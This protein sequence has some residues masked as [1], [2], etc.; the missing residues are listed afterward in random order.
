MIN[1]LAKKIIIYGIFVIVFIIIVSL[2]GFLSSI[3]PP[4]IRID[5]K[6]ADFGLDH[7]EVTFESADGLKLSGWFIP[8]NKSEDAIIVMHGY[9]AN[10]ADLLPV[11]L[12]LNK[13]YNVFLFDFRSFGQ[14]EGK[15]TTAGFKEVKDLEGAIKFLKEE[16]K[17]KN[18]GTFGFSL[19]GAVAII[20]KSE[21]IKAIVADSSY[22][23]LDRM[24][25]QLYRSFFF[26]KWP[27]VFLTNVYS[28]LFLGIDINEVSP[29]NAIKEINTP[30]LLIHAGKD[31]QIPVENSILLNE[32]AKNAE[33]W[34]IENADHGQNHAIKKDEY[35]KRILDFFEKS[36][37]P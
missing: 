3:K 8:H 4:K 26:L 14:S 20:S 21:D 11:S 33:L 24:V 9:P 7:E 15:Y 25:K 18:I 27:F 31:S 34:I 19:G 23:S 16:K 35:E 36:L 22:A 1:L 32:N 17:I 37:K 12:F 2:Y 5:Y 30:V 6:P 13:K 10:K 28:K 29:L